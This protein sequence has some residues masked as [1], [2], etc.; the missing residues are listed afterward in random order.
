MATN[1]YTPV[2]QV[3]T[4]VKIVIGN[5]CKQVA[6]GG[7]QGWPDN[8]P[9][10]GAVPAVRPEDRQP[11]TEWIRVLLT[12]PRARPGHF[13]FVADAA[14]RAGAVLPRAPWAQVSD[15]E[16]DD[17]P[18][19]L[20]ALAEAGPDS[21]ENDELAYL[22]LD[23][24][25][26]ARLALLVHDL[27]PDWWLDELAEAGRE[28]AKMVAIELGA[29]ELIPETKG[30][31]VDPTDVTADE[32][33]TLLNRGRTMGPKADKPPYAGPWSWHL[34]LPADATRRIATVA[35]GDPDKAFTLRLLRRADGGAEVEMSPVPRKSEVILLATFTR[36]G[37]ARQFTL[38]VP[39][40][41]NDGITPEDDIRPSTRSTACDTLPDAAYYAATN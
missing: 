1:T 4:D 5:L 11:A 17:A 24:H 6:S 25:A 23:Q 37:D 19:R 26:L 14:T 10:L 8:A 2:P 18:S 21:F 15:A 39:T 9:P 36:T 34:A 33:A 12:H 28:Y 27:M 31:Y 7:P 20:H 32:L 38:A 29:D 41:A 35:F 30:V 40:E 13:A 16:S 3:S 22:L